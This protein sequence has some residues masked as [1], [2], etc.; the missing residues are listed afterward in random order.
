MYAHTH[1]SPAAPALHPNSHPHAAAY[2]NTGTDELVESSRWFPRVRVKEIT[3]SKDMQKKDKEERWQSES[4]RTQLIFSE[5]ND[6]ISKLD[7]LKKKNK[8]KTRPWLVIWLLLILWLRSHSEWKTGVLCRE[9]L[10]GGEQATNSGKDNDVAQLWKVSDVWLQL[11]EKRDWGRSPQM[12]A[13]TPGNTTSQSTQ[14]QSID[15]AHVWI[16][17][18]EGDRGI[19]F[20]LQRVSTDSGLIECLWQGHCPK[21]WWS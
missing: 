13:V 7:R 17:W 2:I 20:L 10:W 19:A 6:V 12:R 9:W 14:S 3:P 18:R 11:W 15:R 1:L 16:K 21:R 5:H 8:K 4:W